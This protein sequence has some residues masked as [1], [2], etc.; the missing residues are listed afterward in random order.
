[1]PRAIVFALSIAA[2]SIATRARAETW[3]APVGGKP[4]PLDGRIVCPGPVGDFVVEA[5]GTQLRPPSDDAAIGRAVEVRVAV[6]ASACA[7]QATTLTLV[8]TGKLPV[9]DPA[10]ITLAVDEGRIDL[11][12]RALRGVGVAW[13]SGDRSGDDHCVVAQTDPSGDRC[14]VPVG[15]N[16]PAD[17]GATSLA[18]IPPGGRGGADVATFDGAGRRLSPS[19]LAL[20]PARFVLARVVSADASVD[21]TNGAVSR[22]TL[23]HPE[24]V[25]SVDCGAAN[26]DLENGAIVVH[27]VTSIGAF[28]SVRI[29]LVPRAFVQRGDALEP[30]STVSVPVL[31][32]AMSIPSG[33][34]LRGVDDARLVVRL[35]PKCAGD[36]ASLRFAV[37]GRPA[38][39]LRVVRDGGAAF[40]LLRVGRLEG[41]DVAIVATRPQ[42]GSLVGQIRAHARP[43]TA[44]R[45]DLEL[46]SGERIDF[47]PTNRPVF[48]RFA[49]SDGAGVLALLSLEGVYS[50]D[51]T[52]TAT[53]ARA[54]PGAAGYVA[55]RF[56][57]RVTT[58]PGELAATDLAVV[59]ELVQRPIHEA[60]LAM[61][62][63]PA[64]VELLCG[65]RRLEP[66]QLGRVAFVERDTCRL[67]FHRDRLPP[68]QG[69]QKLTLEID[70]SRVDGTPRPEA[71]LA[72][73][74]VLRPGGRGREAWIRGVEGA[75]DHV[76]I[77]LTHLSDD[78]HYVGASELV[79]QAP[80]AQWSYIA[81]TGRARLYATT[82]IPTGL[83]RVSDRAHSGILTLNFGVVSRLTW[84]DDEGHQGFLALE[85][86]MMGVG[87]AN[88]VS[89]EGH[90]LTQV[91]VVGGLGLGVPI[92]NRALATETSINLHAWLEYEISR[93]L[94]R[95]P[96]S[97]LG[98]VFGP[99]ISIGNVGTNF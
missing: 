64:V 36:A 97:A 24:A 42:D 9:I 74:I 40:V 26:C 58:L 61:P 17:P 2:A 87:L 25:A 96:G 41:D 34:A 43:L 14:S 53:T 21:L 6:N 66:G 76:T 89:A 22:I 86:G 62:L 82:A 94:G 46:D 50:A 90:S 4:L 38:E 65:N 72:Q 33:D 28:L 54:A 51:T 8:T 95:Q 88:D 3:Q 44:P 68:E 47:V 30:I 99:S 63:G 49:K 39:T 73:P 77:R 29:R 60:R 1:M 18:W 93:D 84:L 55:L 19:E 52:E 45:A 67:V 59:T 57:Y 31:P 98:F 13:K 79:G 11:R 32:C 70:V 12:G 81:G 27:S 23:T 15:R 56:A 37:S 16:L 48:V 92:A 10:A 69:S 71:H 35:D 75:F 83:Y 91:A 85:G 7:T 80:S 5:N 78:A 20:R